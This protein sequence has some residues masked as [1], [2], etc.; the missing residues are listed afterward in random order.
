MQRCLAAENALRQR[1]VPNLPQNHAELR[2]IIDRVEQDAMQHVRSTEQRT[3]NLLAQ[4]SKYARLLNEEIFARNL[5][6]QMANQRGDTVEA[7]VARVELLLV[8]EKAAAL[9]ARNGQSE[10]HAVAVQAQSKYVQS[11]RTIDGLKTEYGE[12]LQSL[13]EESVKHQAE[14]D[15][16][17]EENRLYIETYELWQNL[18]C[19]TPAPATLPPG[20]PAASAGPSTNRVSAPARESRVEDLALKIKE[21]DKLHAPAYPPI[22]NLESLQSNLPHQLGHNYGVR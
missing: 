7:E 12:A 11:L 15:Y 2:G 16:G 19:S 3:E 1:A 18:Y 13:Q 8:Q 14:A 21:A 17:Y 9:K 10:N 4:S 5:G 22:T 20:L 6:L